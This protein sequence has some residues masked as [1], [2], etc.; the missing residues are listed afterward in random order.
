MSRLPVLALL[1]GLIIV[2]VGA[3]ALSSGSQPTSP[4]PSAEVSPSAPAAIA[5]PIQGPPDDLVG[6][7]T[8]ASQT[9][10][11]GALDGNTSAPDFSV[12]AAAYTPNLRSTVEA[13]GPG[14]IRMTSEGASPNCSKGDVGT[15]QW[16][17]T[18]DGQWLTMTTS[19]DA[20]S[21]R[22]DVLQS[23]SYQ[24]ELSV[25][26][27]GGPGIVTSF[28]PYLELTLPVGTYIGAGGAEVDTIQ[29]ISDDYSFQAWKELDGF[30]DPCDYDAGRLDIEVGMDAFLAYLTEDPRFTVT[31]QDEFLIDGNRAVE[32]RYGIG[33]SLTAPCHDFDGNTNDKT[34]V[35]TWMPHAASGGFW[36]GRIDD[37]G[38]VVVTEVD[39][40][41]LV[42][43][44]V[45]P[46]GD[47]WDI[48]REVLETVRFL[49]ELP[50]APAS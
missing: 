39:G 49:D 46:S 33:E 9:L 44:P 1:A 25:D 32:V 16:T 13:L 47:T 14:V 17:T 4:T 50:V 12:S 7:W 18:S 11:F 31:S 10:L 26:S 21:D 22:R 20:C 23:A 37:I 5:S 35:L 38:M 2:I 41:T 8:A 6:G 40:V 24:R 48:D 28:L 29:I 36:N 45:V 34:G 30:V 19:D 42:L 3:L 15:Y 27:H 43:E